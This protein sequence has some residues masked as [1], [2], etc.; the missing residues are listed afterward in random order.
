VSKQ[1]S[2]ERAL[3]PSLA[4]QSK[5]LI[6]P[7][8][9]GSAFYEGHISRIFSQQLGDSSV[10]G[11]PAPFVA[12]IIREMEV[13]LI[14]LLASLLLFTFLIAIDATSVVLTV[15]VRPRLYSMIQ[16]PILT[17]DLAEH[18]HRSWRQCHRELLDWSLLSTCHV[19]IAAYHL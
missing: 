2:D 11:S 9:P 17:T 3:W 18:Y 5:R 4:T 10:Q 6:S 15:T 1:T 13:P 14:M 12:T 8:S 19:Y 16:Q 7:P